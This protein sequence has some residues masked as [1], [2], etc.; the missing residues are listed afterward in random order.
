MEIYIR[1]IDTHSNLQ[2]S[3]F[4][5]GS[6]RIDIVKYS[7]D[8]YI[9]LY[10]TNIEINTNPR[11][12]GNIYYLNKANN[13]YLRLFLQYLLDNHYYSLF[14]YY[15]S[16]YDHLE[17]ICNKKQFKYYIENRFQ[18]AYN[19]IKRNNTNI[20]V[21]YGH[22]RKSSVKIY[23]HIL[24]YQEFQYG[25][26]SKAVS[27]GEKIRHGFVIAKYFLAEVTDMH[28][29]QRIQST[30]FKYRINP[31]FCMVFKKEYLDQV[32]ICGIKNIPIPNEI[33]E[34][35]VDSSFYDN[36]SHILKRE[37]NKRIRIP[38]EAAGITIKRVDNLK[39]ELYISPNT[40]IFKTVKEKDNYYKKVAADCLEKVRIKYG[41]L[42]ETSK[43]DKI[44]ENL[45]SSTS[46]PRSTLIDDI[47][48]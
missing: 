41:I 10:S 39:N 36:E 5:K 15:S 17:K 6:N 48:F 22:C 37:Y 9:P 7:N 12:S 29:Y 35:W 42:T 19:T 26:I 11:L 30:S 1:D 47:P 2:F 21:Y 32:I 27:G 25:L 24:N 31:L 40:H 16:D 13:K 34:L 4:I 20:N 3:N 38:L 18:N 46:N 14:N 44:L 8:T 33:L 45:L 28:F 43:I 23:D